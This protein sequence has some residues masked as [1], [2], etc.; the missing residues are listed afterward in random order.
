M[1][2]SHCHLDRVDLTEFDGRLELALEAAHEVGVEEFLC[3]SVDLESWDGMMAVVTPYTNVL[4][5][6]GVHPNEN[7][8]A[9]PSIDEPIIKAGDTAHPPVAAARAANP[10]AEKPV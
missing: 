3:V 1:V 9:T 2:D 6:V 5:S 4:C 10:P 8:M 7:H